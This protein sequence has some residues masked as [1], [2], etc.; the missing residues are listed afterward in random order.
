MSK[1]KRRSPTDA[2][3]R[4]L[5]FLA[6]IDWGKYAGAG[7]PC[8]PPLPDWRRAELY[9][10]DLTPQ[11]WAWEFIRRD[12]FYW[13]DWDSRA[14]DDGVQARWGLARLYDPAKSAVE[15]G[16]ALR[17]VPWQPRVHQG[18]HP[19]RIEVWAPQ[20]AIVFDPSLPMA[21]QIEAARRRLPKRS[22][23]LRADV[24]PT[25]LRL[26]DGALAGVRAGEVAKVLYPRDAHDAA[27]RV[28]VQLATAQRLRDD[29]G[30]RALAAM[31]SPRKRRS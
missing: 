11:G 20:I 21:P 29:G 30:W 19:L 27:R 3:A 10:K 17:F 12:L 7:L 2:P 5:D 9:P 4:S 24:L 25:Y 6:E 1:R 8:V 22:P 15:L 31:P 13:D 23:R 18:A 16:E 26:L 28:R 14:S